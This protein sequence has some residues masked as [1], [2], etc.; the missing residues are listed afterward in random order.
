MTVRLNLVG[1]VFGCA[2]EV[3]LECRACVCE[4]I[5][6]DEVFVE[7]RAVTEEQ[8]VAEANK[9]AVAVRE[10]PGRRPRAMPARSQC[11]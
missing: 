11:N 4:P 5:E 9:E 3:A 10:R 1:H 6:D 2:S 7:E 8:T